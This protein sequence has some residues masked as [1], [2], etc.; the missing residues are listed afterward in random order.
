MA[1]TIETI[2]GQFPELFAQNN[3]SNGLHRM[4]NESPEELL[5]D[6]RVPRDVRDLTRVFPPFKVRVAVFHVPAQDG[7]ILTTW[8]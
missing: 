4:L 6:H 3:S 8:S 5:G 1:L 2:F 7:A